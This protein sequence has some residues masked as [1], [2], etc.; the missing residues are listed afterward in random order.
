[1]GGTEVQRVA[2]GHRGLVSDVAAHQRARD[3]AAVAG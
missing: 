2:R 1:M 3:K